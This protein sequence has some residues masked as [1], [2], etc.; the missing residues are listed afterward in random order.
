M[1]GCQSERTEKMM[2]KRESSFGHCHKRMPNSYVCCQSGRTKKK[3][4]KKSEDSFDPYPGGMARERTKKKWWRE[5]NMYPYH[6]ER[7]LFGEVCASKSLESSQAR[8]D[9]AQTQQ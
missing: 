6:E 1:V 3:K 8:R 9:N 4:K 5:L 7:V 2:K